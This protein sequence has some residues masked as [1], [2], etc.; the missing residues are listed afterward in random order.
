MKVKQLQ[1][2]MLLAPIT[3]NKLILYQDVAQYNGSREEDYI[4]V[5]TSTLV[6]ATEGHE[7]MLVGPVIYLGWEFDRFHW[8]GVYKHHRVLAGDTVALVSGY[9]IKDFQQVMR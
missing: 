4:T 2:G 9:H 7:G 1:E 5:C 6:S 3:G 8:D